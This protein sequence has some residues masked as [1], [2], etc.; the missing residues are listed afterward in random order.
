[1]KTPDDVS[2]GRERQRL[3]AVSLLSAAALGFELLLL[4][5]FSI[6]YWHHFAHI[7]IS[8]ALLGAG[9]SGAVLA[10]TQHRMLRHFTSVFVLGAAA[11]AITT[12][13]AVTVAGWLPFNPPELVW[14]SG[15]L[16][17]MAAVF[18]P[19]ALP[20][21]FSGTCIGLTLRRHSQQ[22]GRFYRADMTGAAIGALG[23]TA[24]LIWLPVEQALRVIA[25]CGLVSALCVVPMRRLRHVLLTLVAAVVILGWPTSWLTPVLSSYKDLSRTRLIP[26]TRTVAEISHPTGVFTML[27]SSRVPFRYAPGLSMMS[28]AQPPAQAA[29]FHDGHAAG[30]V[31]SV[32]DGLDQAIAFMAWTPM[33]L[34][35]ALNP[36]PQRVLVAGAGGGADIQHALMERAV[37]IDA[38][39]PHRLW[40]RLLEQAQDPAFVHPQNQQQVHVTT[41][42]VRGFL[43]ATPPVTYDLIQ[44]SPF[45]T[46]APAAAGAGMALNPQYLYTVEGLRR[47]LQCLTDQGVLAISMPLDLPPRANFKLMRTVAQAL[48]EEGMHTP[49]DHMAILRTWNMMTVV[50]SRD[51]L[52]S[53]QRQKV[54]EFSRSRHFDLVWLADLR[55]DE[56]NHYNVL[57]RAFLHEA[58]EHAVS[59]SGA[60]RDAYFHTTPPRDHRPWFNRFFRWHSLPEFWQQRG[61]GSAALLEWETLLLW[62]ALVFALVVSALFIGIPLVLLHYRQRT[63][64]NAEGINLA[65]FVYFA[66]LGLAFLFLEIAFL[67]KFVLFLRDPMISTAV[68]IPSFLFFAGC[69]SGLSGRWI[70]R[71][72][73]GE[74]TSQHAILL[75]V[76][77]ILLFTAIT[78]LLFPIL[79]RVGAQWPA[80]VRIVISVGLISGQAFWMGMPFPLG[81]QRLGLHR[82]AA[83]PIAWG[84]NGFFSV[85]SV[86]AATAI[87]LHGGF[88]LVILPALGC[89][90]LAAGLASR[91]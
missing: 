56:I 53:A 81:I 40:Q 16:L 49:G 20:F 85:I 7:I 17:R 39:D 12:L 82:P 13:L 90:A 29:L 78:L 58:A 38:V 64:T 71:A 14:E 25:G 66:A 73:Y 37:T 33:G 18:T 45:G 50:A 51:I 23:L 2:H 15:Q 87:A 35:Y 43:E 91:L 67:H 72:V 79:F 27:V 83:V 9:A 34:P 52:S 22:A 70:Q 65:G 44:V 32:Q 61:A 55:D 3:L 77:G 41:S 84:I 19:A 24:L 86:T 21:F 36:S 47:A 74:K 30:V 31:N 48:R 60:F 46:A 62:G 6:M 8:M 88:W 54:R 1:M 76:S 69:G 89:Y 57:E 28:P 4:R 80:S 59:H 75:A 10:L 5:V 42:D 68:I 11:F 26:E 63:S